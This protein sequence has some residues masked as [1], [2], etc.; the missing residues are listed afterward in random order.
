[1]AKSVEEMIDRLKKE[2]PEGCCVS[3]DF[4]RDA[5]F[6][7]YQ[8]SEFGVGVMGEL[9]ESGDLAEQMELGL[10]FCKEQMEEALDICVSDARNDQDEA[11]HE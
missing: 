6:V 2:L 9:E 8:T 4:E 5:A 10:R 11:R 3:F 1:M 7:S